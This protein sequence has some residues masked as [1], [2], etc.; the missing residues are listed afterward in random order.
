MFHALHDFAFF[1]DQQTLVKQDPPKSKISETASLLVNNL[2]CSVKGVDDA[3]NCWLRSNLVCGVKET[4]EL[5]V[6]LPGKI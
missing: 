5:N 2:S 3:S 1:T 4:R 6:T